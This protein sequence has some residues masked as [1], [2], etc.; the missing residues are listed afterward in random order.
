VGVVINRATPNPRDSAYVLQGGSQLPLSG[1]LE[2][3]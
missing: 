2:T 1:E 3:V